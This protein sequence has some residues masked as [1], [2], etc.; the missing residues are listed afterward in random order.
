MSIK[1]Y[2]FF[3]IGTLV[4]AFILINSN[5]QVISY[6]DFYNIILLNFIIFFICFFV[7]IIT[8]K[9]S[10]FNFFN[11]VLFLIF[12]NL[13]SNKAIFDSQII[14]IKKFITI[15]IIFFLMYLIIFYLFKNNLKIKKFYN[16][17]F[18]TFS[19]FIAF[20]FTNIIFQNFVNFK[21][22]ENKNIFYQNSFIDIEL[23]RKPDI[24]HI[25]PD[26]LL[27]FEG[28][29]NAGY[30]VK[31]LKRKFEDMN[32]KIFENSVSNYSKTHFSLA[33]YLNGSIIKEDLKWKEKDIY[34]YI[35]NSNLHNL[36]LKNGYQIEWYETRWL[37]SRCK[38]K[39]R[40]ICAN[41]S[42]VNNEFFSVL[43]QS[44]NFN[45]AWIEKVY[46]FI[47]KK[48]KLRELD[49][50]TNNIQKFETSIPRYIY[51]Y[52]EM[53]HPP[54]K[55]MKDCSSVYLHHSKNNIFQEKFNK[56]QYLEQVDCFVLQLENLVRVL[57]DR[58]K[59]YLIIIQA[60]TGHFVH[61]YEKYPSPNNQLD[62]PKE[63]FQAFFGISNNEKCIKSNNKKIFY[64]IDAFHTIINCLSENYSNIEL[65]NKNK[66]YSIYHHDHKLYGKI[67]LHSTLN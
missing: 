67:N 42:L 29:K 10:K 64:N 21:N 55:V 15:N 34:K 27:N 38:N 43:F 52:L 7:N 31:K 45:Y 59:E 40:L 25:I 58:K 33:S 57:D 32:I 56:S 63:V 46:F 24:F 11:L 28:L 16:F 51:G 30:D 49:V 60:D 54:F 8:F 50:I 26:S 36:L 19:I 18:T 37:G 3:F 62:Y 61:G 2:L 53:P 35:N 14:G 9:I 48:Q 65:V 23:K 66:F 17:I 41:K 6:N 5:I 20:S 44:L 13:I 47:F 1:N 22:E 12:C 4:P 39:E